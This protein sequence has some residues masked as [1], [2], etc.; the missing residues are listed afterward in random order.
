MIS[1]QRIRKEYM[2]G[3]N[4]FCALKG[5]DL[6]IEKGEFVAITGASG[7]GKTTLLNIIGCL[8]SATDGTYIL[9]GESV[10]SLSGGRLARLRNTKL[11]FVL[12]DFALLKDQTVL[13]N[14]MFPLLIR[15]C[16]LRKIREAARE[17]IRSVG[18]EGLEKK[19]VVHLSGGQ[20]Q[21]VA[22]ARAI[23]TD[24]DI[25][26]ADEPTGQLDSKTSMEIMELLAKLNQDGK[27]VLVATHDPVITGFARRI[28]HLSDGEIV[29]D[30]PA[31]ERQTNS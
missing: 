4:R 14:V 15:D 18:L 27:T 19:K 8:D 13:F 24:P 17:A 21:R 2:T 5:I 31:A 23:V 29:G 16:P 25:L 28:I 3:R 26:I 30:S 1:L 12:Q 7:S 11:S 6:S 20:Q 10:R 9:D 22:I